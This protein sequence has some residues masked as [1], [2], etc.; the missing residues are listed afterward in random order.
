MQPGRRNLTNPC[1]SLYPLLQ[2]LQYSGGVYSCAR[3]AGP[4]DARRP[5]WKRRRRRWVTAAARPPRGQSRPRA[6][7]RR[8]PRDRC[9][10]PR[11][12]AECYPVLNVTLT[13]SIPDTTALT[14]SIHAARA[15]IGRASR[16]GGAV[17]PL[18]PFISPDRRP[19]RWGRG[20]RE[21]PEAPGALGPRLE[22]LWASGSQP[23]GTSAHSSPGPGL[24]R[25]A[26]CR[27][28]GNQRRREAPAGGRRPGASDW[29]ALRGPRCAG[30]PRRPRESRLLGCLPGTPPQ[31]T[32]GS[33]RVP[34]EEC[35][36]MEQWGEPEGWG[37]K[38]RLHKK[39]T[40]RMPLPVH[41]P[42]SEAQ[43][44]YFLPGI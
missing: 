31:H 21:L 32:A 8:P 41:L 27:R 37:R 11:S 2:R 10:P 42:P 29:P 12:V 43:Y 24:G 22:R 40:L 1:I 13:H 30:C 4:R 20:E 17:L 25:T 18:R 23:H 5:G 15:A 19:R 28:P 7:L 9:R 38:E 26:S 16:P 35:S 36:K 3:G 34:G 6:A 44:F 14:S 39:R 33:V